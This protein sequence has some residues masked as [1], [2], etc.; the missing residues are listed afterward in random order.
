VNPSTF[1]GRFTLENGCYL[2][3]WKVDDQAVWLFTM[4][5]GKC[6]VVLAKGPDREIVSTAGAAKYSK[7]RIL[8]DL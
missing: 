8:E 3:K 2:E 6:R 7:F 4:E 1:V 5:R